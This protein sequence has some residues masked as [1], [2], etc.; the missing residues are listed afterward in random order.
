MSSSELLMP[1]REGRRG[2]QAGLPSKGHG[3]PL[4]RWKGAVVKGLQALAPTVVWRQGQDK[5]A[6]GQ[7]ECGWG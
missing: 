2:K 3:E 1:G 5:S 4:G 7:L 6:E